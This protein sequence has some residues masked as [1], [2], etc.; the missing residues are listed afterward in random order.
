MNAG[1]VEFS[2][3]PLDAAPDALRNRLRFAD[4][5]DFFASLEWFALLAG[6]GTRGSGEPCLLLS[7]ESASLTACLAMQR[8]AARRWTSLTSAYTA[9]YEPSAGQVADDFLPL[10]RML[11]SRPRPPARLEFRYLRE[12]A[13][14]T[15]A[16]ATAFGSAG[17]S[18]DR[19]FQYT[20]R[21]GMVEPGRFDAYFADR[22]ARLRNTWRRRLARA[23]ASGSLETRIVTSQGPI[24]ESAIADFVRIYAASWKP[25]EHFPDFVPALIRLACSLG[26]GRIGV[27][28]IDGTPAAVQFWITQAGTA[29]VYKLAHDPAYA[30]LSVGTLLTAEMI[31]HAIDEDRVREIDFGLGDEAYKRDWVGS[32]RRIIGIEA[33]HPGTLGG[34]GLMARNTLRNGLRRARLRRAPPGNDQGVT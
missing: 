19:F 31:R 32:R 28:S 3:T 21:Y 15:D 5:R 27:L 10:A 17:F 4:G 11:F 16:L 13:G 1:S 26:V 9:R 25:A 29:L 34:R 33:L 24:L 12:D 18:I 20:N 2:C 22:P 30:D 7:T 6:E 14:S 8:V 23:S